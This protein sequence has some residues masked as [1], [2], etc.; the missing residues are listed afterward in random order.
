M[1][2]KED[3]QRFEADGVSVI[4]NSNETEQLRDWILKK[5]NKGFWITRLR[6]TKSYGIHI[7]VTNITPDRQYDLLEDT[8]QTNA[9]VLKSVG[10]AGIMPRYSEAM[11]NIEGN[12]EDGLGILSGVIYKQGH[13][14]DTRFFTEY[15]QG[16]YYDLITGEI[17]DK[18][19]ECLR[20]NVQAQ[21]S[22]PS[23]MKK[24]SM[25]APVENADTIYNWNEATAGAIKL[26]CDDMNLSPKG[27]AQI[28]ARFSAFKAPSV[29]IGKLRTVAYFLGKMKDSRGNEYKDGSGYLSSSCF[30][31][32]L[33]KKDPKKYIFLP[34]AC[35][36]T[37][38]QCRPGTVKVQA[39]CVSDAYINEVVS[40]WDWDIVLK[41]QDM[42][43]DE[44]IQEFKRSYEGN[45]L[46]TGKLVVIT[47][48]IG[49]DEI[50]IDF[51]TDKNGLKCPYDLRYEVCI[52]GLDLPHRP[53]DVSKGA[54]LSTQLLDSM[55]NIDLEKTK[56]IVERHVR[57]LIRDK[58]EDLCSEEEKPVSSLDFN[59][60]INVTHMLGRI[61][62]SFGREHYAPLWHTM[63]NGAMKSMVRRLNRISLPT[64][65]AYV[66]IL[67][68]CAVDFGINVL[69]PVDGY[70]EV[71][72]P[73]AT[74]LKLS[75]I[76][77]IKYPKMCIEE[78]LKGRVVTPEEYCNR[79]RNSDLTNDQK[80]VMID[81]V[82]RLSDGVIMIP[83]YAHIKNMLA[84]LDQ[85][86]DAFSL[87]FDAEIV[88]L[89]CELE[90]IAVIIKPDGGGQRARDAATTECA[91]CENTGTF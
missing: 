50:R 52:E 73:L 16:G 7:G 18:I 86:G 56:E 3:I 27:A 40:T 20:Y 71:V 63:V 48:D 72:C 38:V 53:H 35:E 59:E 5:P 12:T 64:A 17:V 31:E 54:N 32:N 41:Q 14:L 68:D 62:R 66:K 23:Q 45:G 29:P 79:I 74:R 90:V 75:R 46:W 70:L 19:G 84:G 22:T 2:T 81:H 57:N 67:T 36:G 78:F 4:R 89:M 69:K 39:E 1:F 8:I 91:D 76:I 60:K 47:D 42:L 33:N 11:I 44:D 34:E 26:L 88:N 43:T 80:Q 13:G 21:T 85:D 83:A 37:A 6:L 87:Y 55:V 82:M 9:Y 49:A 77:G 30:A 65:G 24:Y 15:P 28:N 61:A 58:R 10:I 25:T 51:L